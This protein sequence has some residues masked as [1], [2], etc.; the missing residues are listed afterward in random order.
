MVVALGS[1]LEPSTPTYGAGVSRAL[2]PV[3][4]LPHARPGGRRRG[5]SAAFAGFRGGWEV[6]RWYI[7]AIAPAGEAGG[8]VGISAR[9]PV[10]RGVQYG[11][12]AGRSRICETRAGRATRTR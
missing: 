4:A 2:G 12:C 11:L 3:L 8:E 5:R 1:S 7:V 9:V 10:R 6:G